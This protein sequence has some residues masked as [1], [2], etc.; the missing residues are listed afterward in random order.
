MVV[1]ENLV[2]NEKTALLATCMPQ[3]H[4]GFFCDSAVK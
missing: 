3:P 1:K 4:R 2:L